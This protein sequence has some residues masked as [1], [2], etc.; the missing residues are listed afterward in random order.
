MITNLNDPNEGGS[1]GTAGANTNSVPTV[2]AGNSFTIPKLT[3]F[4]LTATAN[5]ADTGD[6]AN[7]IYSW[8]EYDLAPSA[9]GQLGTP[10]NSFDVDTDGV[11]RPLFRAYSPVSSPS[12]TFPSIAFILNPTNNNPAGSNNP[13]L[14]YTDTHPTGFSG[15]VCQTGQTCAM[16]ESLPSVS[17]TMN[18]RVSVRDR[19]GGMADAG[20]QVTVAGAAGPF[21]VTTQDTATNWQ[22]GSTQ[23]VT[24]DVS[25]TN[26]NGI[27]TANVKISL[28]TDGGQTFPTTILANTANDGTE[29]ITVPNNPT[30]QARIKIEAVGNI[31]FDINNVNFTITANPNAASPR[32]DFDGDGKTDFSVFRPSEGNWYL[33]RSTA[34]FGA[35]N[36][37]INSDVI[38]PAD[39][40]GDRKTDFAVWRPS[41]V[42]GQP[43]FYVLR[44]SDSTISGV[45][46]GVTTDI[47]VIA[48]YDGDNKADFAVW[49][50]STAD[51]FVLQSQSGTVKHYRFGISTD[52]PVTG[53]FDGDKKA[54][55][56]VFRSSTATWY[57]AKSTDNNVITSQWGLST[58][59]PVFADYDGDD[60]DDIS[61]FRPSDGIW[62]IQKSSGGN[63]FI[64]F[65]TNGDIPVPGD[66]DGDGKYD[67]AVYR[68][69]NWYVNNSTS[70][71]LTI[72]FGLATDRPTP[73]YYLPQ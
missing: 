10:A 61:V 23:T 1:C 56:A 65:G 67:Q 31:F 27:N 41:N 54:D 19:R 66:Y 37:G 29:Q 72:P 47:P 46:W 11:L 44:S 52:K 35:V 39:F 42:D 16:G 36:F 68:N 73:R 43:D 57:I 38:V 13:A 45:A 25:G 40:D 63:S 30:T 59:I 21:R 22:A 71:F 51:Y 28:S 50:P 7:L 55:F 53:D 9:T 12:R 2:S 17:R 70:G 64:P 34:G 58:D 49:R 15:A 18:F 8:E 48:D 6:V 20:T 24:W 32:A 62:Y 4:I 5:D 26:A 60:K 33:Q 14:T 69:G 3:P